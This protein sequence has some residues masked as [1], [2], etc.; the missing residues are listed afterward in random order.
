[1]GPGRHVR[2]EHHRLAVLYLP[3]DAGVLPGHAHGLGALLELGRLVRHHDCLRITQ[4]RGDEPLQRSQRGRPV[5]GM[6][7][8]QRLHPPRCGVPGRLGQL[9]A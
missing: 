4:M 1:M 5:P 7:G 8:Q 3:G 9:P 6:L 2:G